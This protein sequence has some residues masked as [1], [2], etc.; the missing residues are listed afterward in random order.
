MTRRMTVV[1]DDEELYTALKV[2]AART[3]R[4]AKDIV[5]DALH[6]IF[7]ATP[8]EQRVILQRA[9]ALPVVDVRNGATVHQLLPDLGVVKA[10]REVRPR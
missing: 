9:R 2:E 7:A 10:M 1:F 6:L 5:A 4:P 3:H 8:D